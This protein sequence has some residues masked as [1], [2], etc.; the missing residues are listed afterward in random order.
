MTTKAFQLVEAFSVADRK[1]QK[2]V[3]GAIAALFDYI[4]ELERKAQAWDTLQDVQE[5]FIRVASQF[6]TK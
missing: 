5:A 2:Q 3:D 6:P 1:D 4:E